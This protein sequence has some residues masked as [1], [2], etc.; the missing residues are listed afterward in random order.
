MLI[1]ILMPFHGNSSA[2]VQP[3]LFIAVL[4]RIWVYHLQLSGE[5]I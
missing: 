1:H 3:L 2:A 5:K 4:F